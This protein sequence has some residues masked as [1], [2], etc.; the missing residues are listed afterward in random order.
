MSVLGPVGGSLLKDFSCS[1]G[2]RPKSNS[3]VREIFDKPVAK[4]HFYGFRRK[5]TLGRRKLLQGAVD[6]LGI[7]LS[8]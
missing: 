3:V 6:L 4:A 2:M 1:F 8:Y 7:D 5:G